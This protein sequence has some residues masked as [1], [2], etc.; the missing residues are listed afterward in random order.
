[1][2]TNN[3]NQSVN[4]MNIIYCLK[5]D[6]LSKHHSKNML[7]E[8]RSSCICLFSPPSKRHPHPPL[9]SS[10]LPPLF[11]YW[12]AA[13][14][15]SEPTFFRTEYYYCENHALTSGYPEYFDSCSPSKQSG[16]FQHM[17]IHNHTTTNS[18]TNNS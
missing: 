15:G 2:T 10:S 9:S 7:A 14:S 1:M 18:T 5:I 16:G 4:A 6:L 3:S 17:R 11:A 8:H 12:T 13:A